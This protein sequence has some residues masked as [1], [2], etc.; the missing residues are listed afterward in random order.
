M[1][2][3]ATRFI[4][5]PARSSNSELA[6][7]HECA[8]TTLA[9]LDCSDSV[10]SCT[11]G[12][13]FWLCGHGVGFGLMYHMAAIS[14]VTHHAHLAPPLVPHTFSHHTPSHS[15][16]LRSSATAHC[17]IMGQNPTHNV[18]RQVPSWLQNGQ[19]NTSASFADAFFA[20]GLRLDFFRP[21]VGVQPFTAT[22]RS[23]LLQPRTHFELVTQHCAEP[24]VRTERTL[25][26][27]SFCSIIL[28]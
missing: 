6:C 28:S 9:I 1:C 5:W 11:G 16:M 13:Q 22:A 15:A 14:P 8:T 7:T 10:P 24:L 19:S 3:N 18:T 27:V 20:G 23:F 12:D 21:M 2:E 25:Y 26:F 17:H 4:R